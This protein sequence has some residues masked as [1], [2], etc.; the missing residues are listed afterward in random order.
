MSDKSTGMTNLSKWAAQFHAAGELARRK[1]VVAFTTG[2]TPVTD[3]LVK[4]P[5]EKFFQ[6]Q[7]KGQFNRAQWIIKEVPDAENLYY[8]LVYMPKK[9]SEA[10]R[11]FIMPSDEVRVRIAAEDRRTKRAHLKPFPLAMPWRAAEPWRDR[12]NILPR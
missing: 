9:E 3:L 2:N 12:W 4:S 1:Y 5:R 11:Y 6:V 7:V 10:P 8:I